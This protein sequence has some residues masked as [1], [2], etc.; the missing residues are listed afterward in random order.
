MYCT[1]WNK[2]KARASAFV[3]KK[4]NYAGFVNWNMGALSTRVQSS[5][6]LY[7]SSNKLR[8]CL[9]GGVCICGSPSQTRI[10]HTYS[11]YSCLLMPF[12]CSSALFDCPLQCSG[13]S[14]FGNGNEWS[15]RDSCCMRNHT[16]ACFNSHTHFQLHPQ[17]TLTCIHLFM[18]YYQSKA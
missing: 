16:H 11:V 7:C 15:V 10:S 4:E 8:H 18:M 6:K 1:C 9:R 3:P 12:N 2:G 14:R 5:Y 17:Q 13:A